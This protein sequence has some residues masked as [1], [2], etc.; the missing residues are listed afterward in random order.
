MV[1]AVL[2]PCFFAYGQNLVILHTN[3]THSHIEP[4]RSGK[5]AGLGGVV[6][7][8]VFVDSVRNAA[9]EGNVLLVDAGDFS[10]GSSYFTLMN[11]DIEIDVMNAMRYDV[12]C[13]GNHEF[14][15][16]LEEL[17]R[18]VRNADFPV[19]CSN[20]DFSQCVL[21]GVVKPYTILYR[22][23]LKIGF[24]GLL[25]DLTVVVD[26]E[27]ADRIRYLDPA[28]V[29]NRY[30]KYLKEERSCD[31]VICL[32]HLGIEKEV[33]TDRVLVPQIEN[34]DMVIGGHSHT[35]LE[36]PEYI[37]DRT[38]RKIPVVTD[39]LW[40]LNIGQADIYTENLQ[41]I[42]TG[43]EPANIDSIVSAARAENT[44]IPD[45]KD[46]SKED[47]L[48]RAEISREERFE[49]GAGKEIKGIEGKSFYPPLKGIITE[50]YNPGIGHPFIDIAATEGATVYAV[51]DGT[52]IGSG[53]SDET[54]YTLQIQ[55]SDNMVSVYKHN[56]KLLK[57]TGDKVKAGTPVAIAGNTGSLSTAPHL[58]FELW[59]EG[60]AVNPEKYINF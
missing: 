58:H 44:E 12:A 50:K 32:S 18:R 10:Q 59:Y 28:E 3:D 42:L 33:Y 43:G 35:F 2:L 25:T 23:G 53:W 20:Y 56:E 5:D 16:G 30:A 60:E 52:V 51:L 6:E 39:G 14:D 54:G 9:G 8:A 29:T 49:V 17:A 11:G 27:I 26:R 45:Y 48:L 7:R 1:A 37:T 47:S 19:L 38:G 40:G 31:M 22:G 55:H 24:I 41:N 4:V 15:N 36:K 21:D 13:L 57:Q 34:V 46:Y